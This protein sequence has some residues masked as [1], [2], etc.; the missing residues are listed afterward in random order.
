MIRT[1]WVA[2][3]CLAVIGAVAAGRVFKTTAM[4]TIH[5]TPVDGAT[6]GAEPLIKGDRLQM[7]N[8]RQENPVESVPQPIEPVVAGVPNSTP[9]EETILIRHWHDPN[10]RTAATAKPKELIR[11]ATA[12]KDRSASDSRG[13]QAADHTKPNLQTKPCNRT[14]VGEFLRSLRLSPACD[15]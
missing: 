12:K 5:E 1:V 10:A 9:P 14:G 13:S 6:A 4:P 3:T 8:L 7:T 2:L 11:T 15:S